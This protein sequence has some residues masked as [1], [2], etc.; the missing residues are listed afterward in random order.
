MR[1]ILQSFKKIILP[2]GKYNKQYVNY[3]KWSFVSNVIVSTESVIS[4]HCMLSAIET[5]SNTMMT[6]NY[7]GKDIVGQIG[8]LFYMYKMGSKADKEPKK[9]LLYSNLLQQS[10]FFINC[11]TP[12]FNPYFIIF[13]GIA[14][15]MLNIS[16]VG[17]GAINAKCIQKISLENNVGEIY[18]KISVLSTIGSSIGMIIGLS[19][20]PLSEPVLI[21][22]IPVLGGLRIY[23]YNKAIEKII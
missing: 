20:L 6:V 5:N 14:N 7:V 8:G 3:I 21:S 10:S 16:F 1:G 15:I 19:L 9:F 2:S 17:F 18:S 12:Y 4:V 23:S 11:L 13:A 22:L